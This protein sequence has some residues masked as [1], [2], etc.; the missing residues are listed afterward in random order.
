MFTDGQVKPLKMAVLKTVSEGLHPELGL[1]V[2]IKQIN[3]KGETI[4]TTG[5]VRIDAIAGSSQSTVLFRGP[6]LD[7]MELDLPVSPTTGIGRKLIGVVDE[8]HKVS[9]VAKLGCVCVDDDGHC[10]SI[11]SLNILRQRTL[12]IISRRRRRSFS[13]QDHQRKSL[14]K[15]MDSPG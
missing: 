2:E 8:N 5:M 9:L 15:A 10:R 14:W 7:V 11:Y 6:C 12:L 3:P 13:A 1:V 4:I